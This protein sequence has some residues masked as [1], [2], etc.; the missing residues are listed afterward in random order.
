[1]TQAANWNSAIREFPSRLLTKSYREFT[2]FRM[3]CSTHEMMVNEG[4][5]PKKV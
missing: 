3:H 2:K 4:E 5:C 1:M